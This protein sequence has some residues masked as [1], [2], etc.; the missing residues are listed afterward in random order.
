MS[1]FLI[2]VKNGSQDYWMPDHLGNDKACPEAF[3]R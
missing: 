3:I 2:P 1:S